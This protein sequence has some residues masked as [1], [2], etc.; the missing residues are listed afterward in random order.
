MLALARK[1]VSAVDVCAMAK[2]ADAIAHTLDTEV[3]LM[4]AAHELRR[5]GANI[6]EIVQVG[7]TLIG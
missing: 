2:A 1:E 3:K 6:G 7:R 5:T 4:R